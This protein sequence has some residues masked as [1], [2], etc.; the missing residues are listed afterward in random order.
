MPLLCER[1]NY[2]RT[3]LV[4]NTS[5]GQFAETAPA[6]GKY[7]FYTTTDGFSQAEADGRVT[8]AKRKRLKA[9][10]PSMIR[11][12]VLHGMPLPP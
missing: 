10:S 12:E 7:I 5:Q 6:Q 8:V 4:T 9:R 2:V 11:C 3:S 1:L